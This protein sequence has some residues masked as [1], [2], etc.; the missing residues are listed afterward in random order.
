MTTTIILFLI[1]GWLSYWIFKI[2]NTIIGDSAI[3]TQKQFWQQNWK[4]FLL[5]IGGLLFLI[6]GGN[7]IPESWGKLTG[8]YPAFVA[9]GS[10]PSIIMNALPVLGKLWGIVLP[11]KPGNEN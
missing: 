5:S 10:I 1:A 7:D 6:F 9:G 8:P 4:L 11:N 2:P 3:E